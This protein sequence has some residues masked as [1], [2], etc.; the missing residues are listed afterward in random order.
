MSINIPERIK[1]LKPYVTE[2]L[3]HESSGNQLKMD[4][5]E[6]L[7]PCNDFIDK[8]IVEVLNSKK[9]RPNYYADLQCKTLKKRISDFVGIDGE[10]INVYNGSDSALENIYKTFLGQKDRVVIVG[11]TYDNARSLSQYYTDSPPEILLFDSPF[12]VEIN[13]LENLNDPKCVYICNPNNPTGRMFT[14]EQISDF[15]TRLASTIFIIDEAYIEFAGGSISDLCK[16]YNNLIVV[17]TFSKAFGI[18]GLRLGYTISSTFLSNHLSKTRNGKEVNSLAQ[19]AGIAC[20]ENINYTYDYIEE[21]KKSRSY[22]IKSLSHLGYDC[23]DTK[24]NFILIKV[25]KPNDF[26]LSLRQQHILVR[27]VSKLP[28]M[29]GYVRITIGSRDKMELFVEKVK[30]LARKTLT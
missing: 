17:R 24:G 26:V 14:K 21:V 3:F 7:G 20:L 22:T 25:R 9:G 2:N 28:Q 30:V 1:R 15:V 6:Y 29:N 13:N 16:K 18:A 12:E 19:A 23:I 27:D 11:P 8:K 10:N 4:W 5:N